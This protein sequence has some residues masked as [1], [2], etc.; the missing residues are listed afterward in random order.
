[1]IKAIIID[2]EKSGAEVLQ[3]LLQ[4]HCPSIQ[5]EAVENSAES[6][7]NSI[8]SLKPNLVFLDIEMPSATGFDV[9]NATKE[10]NYEVVFTTA[11]EH[12]A[13]KAFKTK[14]VDYLLKPI[15][16]DELKSAVVRVE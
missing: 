10:V 5:I 8:L 2:D 6:G 3:L 12:Y 16:I 4:Q 13:I 1:M 9:I 11:Y 14:A 15:D 7:I